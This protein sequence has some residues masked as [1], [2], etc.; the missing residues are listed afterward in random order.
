MKRSLLKPLL[1]VLA[2]TVISTVV[3]AQVPQGFNY[4]AIARDENEDILPDEPLD[5]YVAILDGDYMVVYDETHAVITSGTGLF[6]IIIGQGTPLYGGTVAGFGDIDW[7][8]QPLFVQ[9][10]ITYN[11]SDIDLGHTELLSVPYAMVS[12]MTLTDLDNPFTLVGPGDTVLFSNA[13]RVASTST[14]ADEEAL[15]AVRRQDGQT[16]FAV[17]NQGVRINIPMDDAVKGAKGGF[18]IGGFSGSK[19]T[20]HNLFVLN[21]DSARIFIDQT[22]D[23]LPKGAKGGFAI[24]GFAYTGKADVVQDYLYIAPDQARIYVKDPAKGAKGGFAIG[25][26]SGSKT[27]P[28]NFMDVTPLNYFIGHES[29]TNLDDIDPGSYN[30]VIGYQAGKGLTTGS[31]NTILGYNAGISATSGEENIIIGRNSGHN[32]TSGIHNTLIGN[33]AG[34]NHTDQNYNVMIG[35]TSGA[36][37]I[38]A[39]YA[40]S[41][42]TFMGINS[43]YQ[44]RNGKNNTLIGTNAGYWLDNGNSNTFIGTDAG[45]SRG[46]TGEPHAWRSGVTSSNNVLIGNRAGY[47][48]TSGIGNVIIGNE[49]GSNVNN[50]QGNIFI[51]NQAGIGESGNDKLYIHNQGDDPPLLY[52]DFSVNQLGINTKVLGKTLSVGGDAYV[53]GNLSA[54]SITVPGTGILTGNLT[55]NVTGDV[56]GN[57]TGNVTGNVEGNL[58]GNVNGVETGRIYLNKNDV[59]QTTASDKFILW[60][61]MEGI[62]TL[63]NQTGAWPCHYWWRMISKGETSFGQGYVNDTPVQIIGGA[64]ESGT[65]IE[66]HFGFPDPGAGYCSVWVQFIEGVL[67]GHYMKY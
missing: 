17:Y 49:A 2:C 64:N 57:L 59:I 43:G 24:G 62:V 58:T 13:V 8:M 30:S 12:Q 44:I 16:M 45:R 53:S 9:T 51:G 23:L 48:I 32:L 66:V 19:G 52:G 67:V 54:G 3:K 47:F 18:A 60:W 61:S 55:G 1:F 56:N 36:N 5:I 25:S 28:T 4:M 11:G 34:Y 20:S 15:F 40:G 42:N 14:P 31:Y 10:V 38:A 39:G 65:A 50:G 22:P 63:E 26:F 41:Y 37:I 6:K 35:T 27:I 7:K 29:G 33:G 21:K 46:E